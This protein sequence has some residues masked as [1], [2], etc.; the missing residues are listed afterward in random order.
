MKVIVAGA[1]ISGLF[2][3]Y[4]LAKEGVEV[5]VYEKET[6]LGQPSRTL[7]VTNELK[8]V[9]GFIPEGT[10]LN[11][12]RYLE[13]FSKSKS[14]RLVLKDPDLVIEREKMVNSLTRLAREAGA[15]VILKHHCEGFD[16]FGKKV[17]VR[18]RNLETNQ[19]IRT[20]ADILV[21]ADGTRSKVTLAASRNG[22]LLAA[23]LQA[24]VRL[25][26]DGKQDTVQVWFNSDRTKY[27]YWLIPESDRT[28]AVGLV[29]DDARQAEACLTEFL[30]SKDLEPFEF[31]SALVPMHRFGYG[32][33]VLSEGRNVFA[34]GDAAAQVKVTTVGGVVT[35]L[36]GARALA[37]AILNG[38]NYPRALREL[39]IE[40]NLHLLIRQ[41][42][43]R[44]N[45]GDYD[46]LLGLIN[47]EAKDILE[48]WNRD[49][50]KKS[51]LRLIW[52]EPRLIKLG[53]KTLLKSFL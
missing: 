48:E 39:K 31:Q 3:A 38:R 8:H 47:G 30:Q 18:L 45:E 7:I 41:I 34:V 53:V 49:E 20:S 11:E 43:N 32:G 19:E 23:L 10:I 44:F 1:S 27:F 15:K 29:A 4:L 36:H 46:E 50:L 40:M 28:A 17:V 25:P 21:G 6:L 26:E 5:E 52:A 9:L 51:F 42:L 2:T 16:L 24:R 12:V 22:H 35:G 37:H 14:A 33:D 13:L